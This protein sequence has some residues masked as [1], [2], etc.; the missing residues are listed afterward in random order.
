MRERVVSLG[1]VLE[2]GPLTGGG[3]RVHARL[4]APPL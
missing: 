2:T 4:P 3:Y 1:G